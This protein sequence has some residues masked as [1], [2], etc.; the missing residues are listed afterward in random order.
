MSATSPATASLDRDR[1]ASLTARQRELLR[2]RTRASGEHFERARAVMPAG[3][4]SQF[5]RNDP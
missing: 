3:V 5:Q 2:E 1:I 4:P